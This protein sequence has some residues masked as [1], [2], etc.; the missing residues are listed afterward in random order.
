MN[1]ALNFGQSVGLNGGSEA[2]LVYEV[3][4]YPFR[5]LSQARAS[6]SLSQRLLN[7]SNPDDGLVPLLLPKT[8][9]E[10]HARKLAVIAQ[11]RVSEVE[12]LGAR[13]LVTKESHS[14][15]LEY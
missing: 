11:R 5:S 4:E 1:G 13:T 9:S 6:V 2:H 12:V 15:Q 10:K 7:S 8:S 3:A 14:F